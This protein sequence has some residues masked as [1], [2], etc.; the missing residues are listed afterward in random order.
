MTSIVILE[1]DMFGLL[2]NHRKGILCGLLLAACCGLPS[3]YAQEVVISEFVASNQNGIKD[4][5]GDRSD[6]I[7]LYNYGDSLVDLDGW[8]LT[9]DA[10]HSKRWLFPAGATLGSHAFLTVFASKRDDRVAG[11]TLVLV[12][13]DPV[14]QTTEAA[15]FRS[16]YGISALVPLAGPFSGRLDNAGETLR[17]HRADSPPP[18]NPV[19]IR[20]SSKTKCVTPPMAAGIRSTASAPI[21]GATIHSA[22]ST[23]LQARE[24]FRQ[25]RSRAMPHGSSAPSPPAPRPPFANPW[26]TPTETDAAT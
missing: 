4:A 10:T 11:K 7:E 2:L 25:P 13:F 5:Y 3:L 15:D 1:F 19:F 17:L 23:P 26:P 6:W 8:A 20:C 21:C 12:S 14:T 22:G 16:H 24:L 18:R 9:D